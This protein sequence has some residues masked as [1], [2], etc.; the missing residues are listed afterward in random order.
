M[1]VFDFDRF[2]NL[3]RKA[4]NNPTAGQQNPLAY[5]PIEDADISKTTNRFTTG[6]TYDDAGQVINDAKFRSM[7]F[8]YDAN[9]RQIKATRANVPDAWTVYDAAGNRVATKINNIWQYVVYD[10]MGKLVAEY[11]EKAD[12]PGGVKYVQQDWQ[13]SV[14]TVTNSNGFA[15]ARID[16]QAFGGEAAK[17]SAKGRRVVRLNKRKGPLH[18]GNRP[19]ILYLA[20][21]YRVKSI[22]PTRLS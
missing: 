15:V 5:T 20:T 21:P 4:A 13:G 2:G 14:R 19:S 12:G 11:G 3:Y 18:A 7:S 22:A 9:G 6:T 1:P 10:A 16:H 17:R 8:A